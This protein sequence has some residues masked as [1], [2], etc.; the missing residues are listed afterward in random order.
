MKKIITL[1]MSLALI[2]NLLAQEADTTQVDVLNKN[3]VT[4]TESQDGT[5]VNV[6]DDFVIVDETDDTIKVK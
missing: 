6:K 4:V 1:F 2:L 5:N 3:I